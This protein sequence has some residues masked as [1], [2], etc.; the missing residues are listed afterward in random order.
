MPNVPTVTQ[1]SGWARGH[2]SRTTVSRRV[3]GGDGPLPGRVAALRRSKSRSPVARHRSD[4]SGHERRRQQ[5]QI[6][7]VVLQC[8]GQ[9]VVLRLAHLAPRSVSREVMRLIEDDE[10]PARR[11]K[12][13]AYAGAALQG[14][15]A[16][17]KPI[18]LGEGVR[19]PVG[20]TRAITFGSG[21]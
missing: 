21:C 18:V 13:T 15:D 6:A 1:P 16:G 20:P 3:R 7:R 8:L 14:V 9:L 10:V 19:F 4:R 2:E 12:E 11:V 5:D 17:D